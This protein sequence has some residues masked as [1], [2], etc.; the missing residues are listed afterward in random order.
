M[1]KY[2]ALG[3]RQALEYL[4]ELGH[5]RILFV[6]GDHSDSYT[7]KEEAYRSL[8]QEK[9]CFHEEDIVDIGE[10]N[11]IE[12][13]TAARNR[14]YDILPR[15]ETTAIF[16]CND[17][18]AT[19]AIKAC[20]DR[21]LRIPDDM[22]IV[23]YD[24]NIPLASLIEPEITTMDQNMFQ[25]GSNAAVVLVEMIHGGKSKRIT[26]ENTLIVRDSTGPRA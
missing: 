26:L 18:M 22:S 21:S 14:L 7:I 13:V 12:T 9:K 3:T 24:K 25:L 20:K 2:E 23:G 11:S 5:R 19:G 17:L 10:G 15:T 8:M 16:C 4:M 1:T 6:R